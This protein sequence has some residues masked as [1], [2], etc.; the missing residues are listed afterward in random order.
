MATSVRNTTVGNLLTTADVASRWKCAI[1][2]LCNMRS[3]GDGPAYIKVGYAVFY[4]LEKV[5]AYERR[6]PKHVESLAR[7]KPWNGKGKKK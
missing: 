2:T 5:E 4:P 3:Q 7:R 1:G 6:F